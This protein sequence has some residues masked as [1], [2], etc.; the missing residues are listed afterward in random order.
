MIDSQTLIQDNK[1]WWLNGKSYKGSPEPS[2]LPEEL[3]YKDPLSY[4][5]LV[6]YNVER[7]H[8]L[9]HRCYDKIKNTA[10]FGLCANCYNDDSNF[11]RIIAV[12]AKN[13]RVY[14]SRRGSRIKLVG[15][16]IRVPV[17]EFTGKVRMQVG[18]K[19]IM[20][21]PYI[22]VNRENTTPLIQDDGGTKCHG[23]L[24]LEY[25]LAE[26]D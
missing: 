21:R 5:E 16:M 11:K 24:P 19:R 25:L 1:S 7:H 4:Y 26:M 20:F 18:V 23:I 13:H 17:Y 3:Q 15:D 2:K 14:L 8:K 10:R 9:C 22:D 6:N 12:D